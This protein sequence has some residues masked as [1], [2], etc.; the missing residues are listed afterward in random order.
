MTPELEAMKEAIHSNEDYCRNL[1]FAV[2][3]KVVMIG[4]A[5]ALLLCL[6]ERCT[7]LARLLACVEIA[8]AALARK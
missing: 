7:D 2:H 6:Q 1:Q 3:D 4:Q 8:D 5:S